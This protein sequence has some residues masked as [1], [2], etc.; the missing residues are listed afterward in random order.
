MFNILNYL[1]FE[2]YYNIVI[3]LLQ[4]LEL[5]FDKL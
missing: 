4:S 3:I 1:F 2:R 5:K